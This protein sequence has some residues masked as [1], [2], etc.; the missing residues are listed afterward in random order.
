MG[1]Q[2][3]AGGSAARHAEAASGATANAHSHVPFSDDQRLRAN[4]GRG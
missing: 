1:C 3:E 2:P 4:C